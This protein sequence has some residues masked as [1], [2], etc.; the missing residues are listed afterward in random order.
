MAGIQPQKGASTTNGSK[1]F[2]D[3]SLMPPDAPS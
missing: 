1:I 2:G 3:L